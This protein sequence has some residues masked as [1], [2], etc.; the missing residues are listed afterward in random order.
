MNTAKH[1]AFTICSNNYMGQAIALKNSLLKHNP[2]FRFYIILVDQL[3]PEADYSLC[4]PA[5]VIPVAEVP[6]LDLQDLIARYYIIEFNTAVKASAFKHL[7]AQNPDAESIYYLDPDLYFY[8]AL[9]ETN[10]LLKQRSGVL[11][12]HILNPIPRDGKQP[13][14]NT[15]LRF[16]IYN[17]GF[18]GLN[19]QHEATAQLLDW[20]EHRTLNHGYDRPNKGYF[21]DQLWMALA[22]IFY[23]DFEVLR[24][25]NYNMA[26]WNL[27]ERQIVSISEDSVLL[28]DGSDLVFYHFSKL[29][30]DSDAISR[31]YNRYDFND[32]P[33]LRE[34]YTGYRQE[35]VRS[36]F[37]SFRKIPIAYPVRMQSYVAPK[38]GSIVNRMLNYTAALLLR[39]AKKF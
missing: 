20:W 28:N 1:L 29:A 4:E 38:K 35:L 22:P 30:E 36:Q 31:E 32:F 37:D 21:V 7:I 15:F 16:G 5:T 25:F 27:H 18:L 39:L 24:T 34:L 11:T 33:L 13:D 8:G 9:T 17:L 23:K 6:G 10:T 3:H 14:E 19:P 12:P 2:D 26:P